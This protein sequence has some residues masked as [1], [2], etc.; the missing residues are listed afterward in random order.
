MPGSAGPALLRARPGPR[1]EQG[2][3]AAAF[4]LLGVLPAGGRGGLGVDRVLAGAPH[5]LLLFAALARL[6]ALVLHAAHDGDSLMRG[7]GV[8][9]VPR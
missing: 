2:V 9:P 3:L 6:L 4:G 1:R 5:A 7:V 8:P